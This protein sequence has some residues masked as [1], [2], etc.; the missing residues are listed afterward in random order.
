VTRS[1]GHVVYKLD[2]RPALGLYRDYLGDYS[3]ELPGSALLFP[4]SVQVPG[5]GAAVVRTILAIDDDAQ[6]MTFAGDV[7]EGSS[8]QLMR[9]SAEMLVD[10]A[11]VAAERCVGGRVE[12][13][14]RPTLA[15]GI[16]CVGRR[17]V[18]GERAEDELDAVLEVLGVGTELVGFYSNGEI[19]TTSGQCDLHNQTM[20]LTLIGEV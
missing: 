18:L 14:V 12:T 13:P 17:L 2:G 15:L 8:A 19:S 3:A 5:A 6:S 20:T 10:G 4:L 16:S 9:A 1:A 7:P 11:L